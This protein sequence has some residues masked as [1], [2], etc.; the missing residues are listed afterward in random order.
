LAASAFWLGLSQQ[1]H[2]GPVRIV[3]DIRAYCAKWDNYIVQKTPAT[4]PQPGAPTLDALLGPLLHELWWCDSVDDA[5]P[6]IGVEPGD[7]QVT[8]REIVAYFAGQVG[9]HLGNSGLK[10][11]GVLE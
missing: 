8:G 1:T 11:I 7:G 9:G 10:Q 4:G 5:F 3:D 2:N 6:S